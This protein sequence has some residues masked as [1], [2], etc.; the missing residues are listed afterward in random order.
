M[1]DLASLYEGYAADVFRFAYYLCGNRSDAEDITSETFVRAWSSQESIKTETVK[2]YLFTIAR[3]LFLK[4]LRA[5]SRHAVLDENVSD[6]RP[7]AYDLAEQRAEVAAVLKAMQS[8]SAIDRAA[9]IMRTYDELPYQEIARVLEITETAA[10]V[11]V[12]RAR[13]FLMNLR[14]A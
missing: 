7:S 9:L 11:K 6:S 12:H 8:L 4:Q 14:R 5:A 3:N 1:T 2:G 10:K 13:A